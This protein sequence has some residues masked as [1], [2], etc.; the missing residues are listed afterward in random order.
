[1]SEVPLTVPVG[2]V[3]PPL[4]RRWWLAPLGVFALSRL[5][6]A[7]VTWFATAMFLGFSAQEVLTNWDGNWYEY[8]VADG[9]PTETGLGG[10]IQWRRTAF[11]PLY[12]GLVRVLATVTPLGYSEAGVALSLLCGAGAMILLYRLVRAEYDDVVALRTVTLLSFAPQAFVFTMVYT[13]ALAL[14]LVVLAFLALRH[15]RYGATAA[16]AFLGA[17]TRPT[18]FLIAVPIAIAGWRDYRST[19]RLA[20]LLPTLA[21]PAGFALWVGYVWHRTGEPTGYFQLQREYWNAGIDFGAETLRSVIEFVT[22]EWVDANETFGVIALA[23]AA[24]ALVVG[25]R[26]RMRPEWWWYTLASVALIAMNARQAS[27]GRFMLLAFPLFV[28]PAK[29]LR[30]EYFTLLV[31][32]FAVL[33]GAMFMASSAPSNRFGP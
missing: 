25:W 10:I 31:A 17:L 22:L 2:V 13:E 3:G 29:R 4:G 1:M 23:A 28:V 8:I 15:K 6:T 19:G 9:Y 33:M 20:P 7:V 27:A 32:A 14:L 5:L 16:F 26:M 21:A 12:P 11:F 18:G 30:T 24:V